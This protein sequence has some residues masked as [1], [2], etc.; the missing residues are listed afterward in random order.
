MPSGLLKLYLKL[1][2]TA[3]EGSCSADG[4]NRPVVT[5][6]RASLLRAGLIFV[7]GLCAIALAAAVLAIA[8]NV[9]GKAL[10]SYIIHKTL[11]A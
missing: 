3:T 4:G 10:S 2:S 11:S 8:A 9:K 7:A 6:L 5:K 1:F